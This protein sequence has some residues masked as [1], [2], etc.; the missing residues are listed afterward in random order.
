MAE[1]KP[2]D[3]NRPSDAGARVVPL[4]A[5]KPNPGRAEPARDGVSWNAFAIAVA[6]LVFAAAALVVQTQRVSNQAERI[7]ALSGQV[8]D[9]TSQLSTANAQLATYHARLGL[10]RSSV[11]AVADQVANL[12]DLVRADPLTEPPPAIAAPTASH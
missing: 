7:G 6:L 4:G 5:Q 12:S 11:A 9:L 2:A 1:A 3:P 8:E 10:I